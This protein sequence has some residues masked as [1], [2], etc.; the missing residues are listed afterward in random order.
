MGFSD[1]QHTP[2][3]VRSLVA[4]KIVVRSSPKSSRDLLGLKGAAAPGQLVMAWHSL[5]RY[6]DTN[7]TALRRYGTGSRLTTAGGRVPDAHAWPLPVRGTTVAF[8]MVVRST[9]AT[10]E[11]PPFA[12]T[13]MASPPFGL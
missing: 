9:R 7:K 2:F 13:A 12:R 1:K 10:V 8:N 4:H 11:A 6:A 3:V 5:N